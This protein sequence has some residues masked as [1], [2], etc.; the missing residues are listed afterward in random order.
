[1][2]SVGLFDETHVELI[3]GKVVEMSPIRSLH[4]TGVG[5]VARA[6]EAALGEGRHARVQQP[7]D[8]GELSEPEP[9]VALVRGDLRDYRDNHPTTALVVVEVAESSLEYDRSE[10]ASLYARAGIP[11]YWVENL[12]DDQLEVYRD[13]APDSLQPHSFGYRDVQVLKRGDT[14]SPLAAPHATIAVTDLLP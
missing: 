11:E 2:G 9:D 7:L 10:K 14:V 5:I 1:M 13:P 8:I 6:L 12:I 4:T 3:E